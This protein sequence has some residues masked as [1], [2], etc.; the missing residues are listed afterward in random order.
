MSKQTERA[1]Q[2]A[3]QKAN[4]TALKG[5]EKA[6][7]KREF[8]AM[9]KDKAAGDTASESKQGHALKIVELAHKF[10][11]KQ[12]DSVPRETI[13]KHWRE[14]VKLL[15]MELAVS[16]NKFAVLKEGKDGAAPTAKLTGYGDNVASIARG[17]VEFDVEIGESFRECRE[18]VEAARA[19]YRRVNDPDAAAL[20]DAKGAADEA[21]QEL[22]K[23][24]FDTGHTGLI[25][26]LAQVLADAKA[27]LLADERAAGE[28]EQEQEAD[29]SEPEAERKAA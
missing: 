3:K 11:S 17:M 6:A 16:G 1:N 26:T 14:N 24:V 22:R 21:W 18:A 7:L 10:R 19:E 23:A 9:A 2:K 5:F 8:D 29:D 20:S 4:Q 13:V 12:P 28:P 25:E 27:E 15:T